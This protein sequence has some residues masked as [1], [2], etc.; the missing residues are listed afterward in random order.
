[1]IKK[2][3]LTILVLFSISITAQEGTSSPYSF[4]GIGDIKFKGTVDTRAMGGVSVFPDSIHLNLQ[5]PASYSAL[6]YI[7]FT[8]GGN[9]NTTKFKTNAEQESARRSAVDYIAL[10]IPIGKLGATFGLMPFS[11]VGYQISSAPNALVARQFKGSGGLNKAF[12]GFG[13]QINKYLSAGADVNFNFGSITTE[14]VLFTPDVFYGTKELNNS[15]ISGI[16]INTGFI[17]NRAVTKKVNLI[18]SVIFTPQSALQSNNS[19]NIATVQFSQGVGF[20]PSDAGIDV[21]VENTTINLPRKV[22]LA[23]GLNNNRKWGVGAEFINQQ[24]SR[25]GNRFADI[26]SGTFEDA[27]RFAIGGFIIPKYNSFNS[28]FDRINYRLGMRTENTGLVINQKS[29]KDTA[30]TLGLGLPLTGYG[31]NIN[32]TFEYGKRGTRAANLVEENYFNVLL[33]VSLSDRW[34]IKRK[35]D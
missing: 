12:V 25:Y 15:S 6:K 18:S 1:M 2:I 33:S 13:Y 31:S 16:N 30:V 24:F 9:Y 23:F 19:R 10:G 28:Y 14:S 5:N 17:Y 21:N 35:Y 26:T 29:I 11:S 20:T 3:L 22:A 8:I 7:A 34:F 32:L 4:Y 27:N